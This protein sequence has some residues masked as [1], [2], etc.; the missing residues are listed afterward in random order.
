MSNDNPDVTLARDL[1]LDSERIR[2][3]RDS[4]LVAADMDGELVMM[5]IENGEYYGVGGAGPRVWELLASPLTVGQITAA[6]V[7]EF[8]VE[9][10]L[11]RAD[12]LRFVGQL[13][14]MGLLMQVT[15]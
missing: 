5:S 7:E 13:L 2:L 6:I 14:K 9:P 1:N 10:D 8:E 11:C 15:D 12:M 4:G 3:V